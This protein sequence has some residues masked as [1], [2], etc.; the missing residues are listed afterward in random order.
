MLMI[1]F[2]FNALNP[3]ES[4][5]TKWSS[6]ICQHGSLKVKAL[7]CPVYVAADVS[8]GSLVFGHFRSAKQVAWIVALLCH[9]KRIIHQQA[10]SNSYS[11]QG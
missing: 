4:S 1:V 7:L 6:P 11:L 5:P 9:C 2:F 8:D 3:N 10:S